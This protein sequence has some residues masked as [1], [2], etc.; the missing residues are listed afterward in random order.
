MEERRGSVLQREK[1]RQLPIYQRPMDCQETQTVDEELYQ[2]ACKRLKTALRTISE[3]TAS[4]QQ[5]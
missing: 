4:I 5:T 3:N 2:N 1:N